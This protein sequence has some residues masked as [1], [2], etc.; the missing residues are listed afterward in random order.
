MGLPVRVV[1]VKEKDGAVP[2]VAPAECYEDEGFLVESGPF[3]GLHSKQ[4]R[5]KVC[6]R[7][8]SM[9]VELSQLRSIVHALTDLR[10]I[11]FLC[12]MCRLSPSSRSGR[13][14]SGTR[15]TA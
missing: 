4:A 5:E 15:T 11:D 10:M 14:A 3:S 7:A 12:A 9:E 6:A 1:V 8:I 2:A 13:S